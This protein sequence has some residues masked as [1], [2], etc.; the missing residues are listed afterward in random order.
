MLVHLFDIPVF[1][2]L[3]RCDC[4]VRWLSCRTIFLWQELLWENWFVGWLF[5]GM[6]SCGLNF[7]CMIFLWDDF[8]VAYFSCGKILLWEDVPVGWLLSGMIFHWDDIPVGVF[9]LGCGMKVV[10]PKRK[11]KGCQCMFSDVWL[12]RWKGCWVQKVLL[13]TVITMTWMSD[14]RRSL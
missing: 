5:C 6:I 11:S 1:Y 13:E 14:G 4:L 10:V 7:L 3:Q 2:T 9:Y 12:K 8:P